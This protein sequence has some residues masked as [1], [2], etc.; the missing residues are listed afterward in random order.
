[1]YWEEGNGWSLVNPK[2]RTV[3]VTIPRPKAAVPADGKA[4]QP[5][6]FRFAVTWETLLAHPQPVEITEV[7]ASAVAVVPAPVVVVAPLEV[8]PREI[9]PHALQ[10]V[11]PPPRP[12]SDEAAWEMVV[13]KMV[14]H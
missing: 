7:I 8:V 10:V 12:Q 14:R 6:E 11:E 13:P 5:R 9:P 1:V 2:S 3:V 4:E